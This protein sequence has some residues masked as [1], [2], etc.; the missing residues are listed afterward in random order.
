MLLIKS[1]LT[2]IVLLMLVPFLR[3]WNWRRELLF[4]S[5]PPLLF[6]LVAVL[7]N[8]NLGVRHILPVYPFLI[9]LA[10]A[11]GWRLIL[12]SRAGAVAVAAL[13]L[14]AAMSSL[15]AFPNYLAYS[16]EAFGGPSHTYRVVTDANAD[17][18][19]GLK[20]VKTYVDKNHLSDCWFDYNVPFVNP[21]YYKIGCKPLLSAVGRFAAAPGVVV[22][23][24][25]AG[26]ILISATELEGFM[27]GPDILNP[28]EVFKQRRPDARIGNIVL[29]YK[30]LF[31]VPLLAAHSRASAAYGLLQQG[32][33]A[34]ALALCQA[35]VTLAPNSAEI[36]AI[37]A[38]VLMAASQKAEARQEAAEAIRLARAIH[39]DFQAQLI[40]YLE[41][42]GG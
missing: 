8:L 4:L 2:L 21:A 9:V 42:P 7:S 30:G 12:R 24:S 10:A 23:P 41:H 33:V 16:N 27:W 28:Y 31:N 13:I 5:I 25:I 20:W 6:L 18:G 26:T 17:W 14:F 29:V 3:L 39:P 11:A 32:K 35:A 22:P 15:L 36:H 1:T 34:E 40:R 38:Q 37:R 19:Q